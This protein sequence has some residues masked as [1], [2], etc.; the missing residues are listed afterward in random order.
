[1]LICRIRERFFGIIESCI[2]EIPKFAKLVSFEFA[3]CNK[4]Q[5]DKRTGQYCPVRYGGVFRLVLLLFFSKVLRFIFFLLRFELVGS[6]LR[7][8]SGFVGVMLYLLPQYFFPVIQNSPAVPQGSCCLCRC[9]ACV[10][11]RFSF[12]SDIVSGV[13][14]RNCHVGVLHRGKQVK[15]VQKRQ[16]VGAGMLLHYSWK[17]S[18]EVARR[19]KLRHLADSHTD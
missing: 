19:G 13:I 10:D 5:E 1:M 4:G 7:G 17:S 14:W 9:E 18:S 6:F 11:E 8:D 2:G 3:D 15:Q 16:E 12:L